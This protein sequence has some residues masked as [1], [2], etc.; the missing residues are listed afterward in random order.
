M[1]YTNLYKFREVNIKSLTALSSKT[2]WFANVD[3]LN[4]PFEFKY[5]IENA[6]TELTD[7]QTIEMIKP[8]LTKF[9]I[10]RFPN[11]K[12]AE[13]YLRKLKALKGK[14]FVN[15]MNEDVIIPNIH[16][17][18]KNGREKFGVLSLSSDTYNLVEPFEFMKSNVT[19]LH[20]WSLYSNG[21]RG[22]CLHFENEKLKE[23]FNKKGIVIG[24]PIE[25]K[26]YPPSIKPDL[27]SSNEDFNI[28]IHL[29]SIT[30]TLFSKHTTFEKE[31]EYR[32]IRSEQGLINYDPDCLK[33]VYIGDKMPIE[34]QD[35]IKLIIN[36]KYPNTKIC[37]VF[38]E[39][40]EYS[41]GIKHT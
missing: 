1:E 3:T 7:N 37:T 13:K 40:N 31:H 20:L 26:L 18:I 15:S 16:S 21:M 27:K 34:Q 24:G 14:N 9:D 11:S 39:E 12:V 41:V 6:F 28:K 33:T 35:L 32:L 19:N 10:Q 29:D 17:Q 8:L 22:F 4:D 38:C 2:L 25:Y 23:S 30:D 5:R 36:K